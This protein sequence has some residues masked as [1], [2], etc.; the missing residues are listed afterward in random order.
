M[1]ND[2]SKT[3]ADVLIS[4]VVDGESGSGDWAQFR[5][6]AEQDPTLW[7][8]LA[9][10]QREHLDLCA[11]VASAIKCADDVEAPAHDEM[12]RRFSERIRLVGSWGG[13]AAAAAIILVW[14]TGGPAGMLDRN[15]PQ[16]M[17]NA[18]LSPI[19]PL[20][21]YTPSEAYHA[22]LDKGREQGLVVGEVP[23]VLLEARP[24][25]AGG[26]YEL[27]YLRQVMERRMVKELNGVAYDEFG[28]PAPVPIPQTP[29]IIHPS[30]A[31]P[32]GGGVY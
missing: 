32:T 7:R 5:A 19:N 10:T 12:S 28:R 18:S 20:K 6:L 21:S 3:T 16:T 13:W 8:E 30:P 29:I 14:A 23:T 17:G 9:E 2:Q 1:S 25:K 4:R 15:Q 22:Y 11:A 24:V 31:P 27:I 26:G